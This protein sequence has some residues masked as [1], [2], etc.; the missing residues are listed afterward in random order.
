[1]SAMI[2]SPLIARA[3]ECKADIGRAGFPEGQQRDQIPLVMLLQF[4]ECICARRVQKS[5]L[6]LSLVKPSF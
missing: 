1:M 6:S 2:S 3:P 5:I 4:S